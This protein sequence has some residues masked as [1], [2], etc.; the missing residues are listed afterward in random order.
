[1]SK[2]GKIT[3]LKTA[4]QTIPNFWMNLLLIPTEICDKIEKKMNEFWWKN[5]SSGRGI[6]WLSWDKLCNVKEDAGLGFK[7]L[8]EFNVAMLAKQAWRL[9]NNSNPMV[10]AFMKARYYPRNE[11]LDATLGNNPSYLWRSI[12]EA[13]GVVK[14]GGRKRIGNGMTTKV[15]KVPWLPCLENGYLST[16]TPPGLDN[17]VVQN[18][19]EKIREHGIW[20]YCLVFVMIE[21]KRLSGK[22]LYL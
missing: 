9:L 8:R 13:Q 1:M 19:F 10:T 22:F 2:A 14:Q 21:I 11:F 12:M 20:I 3:L 5:R 16:E 17:I 15:W 7:K 4:A 18:L 6:K